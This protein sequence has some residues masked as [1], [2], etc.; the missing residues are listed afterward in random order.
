MTFKADSLIR[1]T[2]RKYD[3]GDLEFEDVKRAKA[4]YNG[5][6]NEELKNRKGKRS[7]NLF[8][9]WK[10]QFGTVDSLDI[11]AHSENS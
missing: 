11:V 8:G 4:Q 2:T 6:V 10:H 7:E 3:I 1:E 5:I 9:Q